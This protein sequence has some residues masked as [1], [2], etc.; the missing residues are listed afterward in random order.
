[1]ATIGGAKAVGMEDLIGSIEVGKKADIIIVDLFKPHIEPVH[2]LVNNLIYCAKGSD[3]ETS[4]ID[5]EVV[6]EKGQLKK[7]DEEEVLTRAMDISAEIARQDKA[8]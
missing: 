8:E 2:D 6:L 5:G 4:I 3:V 1:M 7:I